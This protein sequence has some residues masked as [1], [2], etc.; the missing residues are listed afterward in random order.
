MRT[1]LIVAAAGLLGCLFLLGWRSEPLEDFASAPAGPSF[2]VR[3]VFPA[4]GRPFF[5]LLPEPIVSEVGGIPRELAYDHASPGAKPGT[6]GPGHLELRGD[7]WDLS[8]RTDAAGRIAPETRVLFTIPFEESHWRL[9]CRPGRDGDGYLRATVRPGR[10]EL[11]GAFH[12]E[13]AH[14]EDPETGAHAG[15][16]PAP[17]TV[18]G[19][20]VGLPRGAAG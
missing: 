11:D 13:L 12:V 10:N 4:L 17:I 14:C 20:F 7:G 18:V 15:W 6:A 5:G 16:P 2:H 19:R 8:L 1:W 3:V 9:R